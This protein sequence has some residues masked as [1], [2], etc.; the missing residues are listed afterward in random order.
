MSIDERF[1]DLAAGLGGFYRTWAIYLGIEL[2]LFRRIRAAAPSGVTPAGLA[3]QAGCRPEVIETWLQL[4]HAVEL[5]ELEDGRATMDEDV[6]LI[7]LDDQRPE[8][9]GG[10][11]V[12]TVVG[13][14]DYEGLVEFAR[15]GR[16]IEGRPAR[17]HRAIEA[18]TAQDIAVFFQE[19]LAMMPELTAGLV[20][21]GRVL[22]VACG[23][24]RWLLAMAGRF[25][26]TT[27]VGVEYEP[28]SLARAG[29]RVLEAGLGARVSIEARAVDDLPWPG[30]FNLVYFQDALHDLSDP[31][32][33]LRAGWAC[34]RPAGRLVVL[35][36]CLPESDEETR[37]LH[38]AMMWGIQLDQ[39]FQGTRLWD[40]AGFSHLFEAAGIG[41]PSVTDLPSGASLFVVQHT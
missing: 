13:S 41:Q 8:Y 7:L 33:A 36:W 37:S 3:V 15:A 22:D 12:S 32:A 18:L 35:D 10:Q 2:G 1:D 21:G 31:V 11:F 5:V 14:L 9:L 34:V 38:G 23:G 6:A 28:D 26:E 4:A 17:Y 19:G 16:P 24:G 27:L 30:E 39:L 29:R 40:H 20:R 25:P